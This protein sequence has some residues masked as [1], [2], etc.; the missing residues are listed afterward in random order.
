MLTEEDLRKKRSDSSP[1]F[2]FNRNHLDVIG[3]NMSNSLTFDES[4]SSRTESHTGFF[5]GSSFE[6]HGRDSNFPSKSSEEEPLLKNPTL[7]SSIE[8]ETE[9]RLLNEEVKPQFETFHGRSVTFGPIISSGAAPFCF[10]NL[11]KSLALIPG[12]CIPVDV[13]DREG[14]RGFTVQKRTRK[15][16]QCVPVTREMM[17][18]CNEF[19][20]ERKELKGDHIVPVESG[21]TS[22]SAVKGSLLRIRASKLCNLTKPGGLIKRPM[23]AKPRYM[24]SKKSQEGNWRLMKSL[25]DDDGSSCHQFSESSSNLRSASHEKKH[26]SRGL[27]SKKKGKI[28]KLWAVKLFR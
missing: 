11:S 17:F 28:K 13:N 27:K 1:I 24:N 16:N 2:P 6:G 3:S 8:K 22:A 14:K 4:H 7:R 5:Q 9:T 23:Q 10:S 19:F 21:I 20:T 15:H 26:N 18:E 12:C 25:L